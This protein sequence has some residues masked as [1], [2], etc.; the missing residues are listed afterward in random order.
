MLVLH[1][2]D[3]LVLLWVSLVL[4]NIRRQWNVARFMNSLVKSAISLCFKT[5]QATSPVVVNKV[6]NG[7]RQHN[8]S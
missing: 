8:R 2:V 3:R 5:H 7:A 1:S 6:H 4:C